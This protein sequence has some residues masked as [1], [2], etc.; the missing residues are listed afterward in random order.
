MPERRWPDPSAPPHGTNDNYLAEYTLMVV[1]MSHV[2]A[3]SHA[4]NLEDWWKNNPFSNADK[5]W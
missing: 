2:A 5:A 3:S 4:N 1:M